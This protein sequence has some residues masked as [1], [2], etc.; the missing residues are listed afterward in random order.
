MRL[1]LKELF[2]HRLT[3]FQHQRRTQTRHYRG[4]RSPSSKHGDGS[5]REPPKKVS[6][7]RCVLTGRAHRLARLTALQQPILT[8]HLFFPV[9]TITSLPLYLPPS[10]DFPATRSFGLSLC[11]AQHCK[12]W[13]LL[14]D[15]CIL[16][17]S[18]L[19]NRKKPRYKKFAFIELQNLDIIT[20]NHHQLEKVWSNVD[21]CQVSDVNEFK[22]Y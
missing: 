7:R 2:T 12:L 5:A 3:Q 18:G 8:S 14:S 21:G 20:P 1:F 4:M 13:V 15:F 22:K 9:P 17:W 19:L 10:L 16:Y 11:L 6:A